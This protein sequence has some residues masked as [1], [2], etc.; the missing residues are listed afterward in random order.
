MQLRRFKGREVGDVMRQVRETLGPEAVILHT[1]AEHGARLWGLF[2]GAEVEIVAAVDDTASPQT[3]RSGEAA[4]T[5]PLPGPGRAVSGLSGELGADLAEMKMMLLRAV[6]GRVLPG[7]LATVYDTLVDSGLDAARAVR[8][9]DAITPVEGALTGMDE[10]D[11]DALE[12][13]LRQVVRVAASS[14]T[15]RPSTI[16][17]VGPA[18]AG[19]TAMVTKLAVHSHLVGHKADIV[20]FDGGSLGATAQLEAVGSMLGIPWILA[21]APDDV[22]RTLDSGPT[23]GVTLIDTPGLG[24]RNADELVALRALLD[25]ASP[26][27]V[28]LVLPAT[29]TAA[30]GLAAVRRFAVLG[31][32][33]LAFT[34]LDEAVGVGPVLAVAIESALPLSYLGTGREVPNDIKPATARDLARR[35]LQGER[36]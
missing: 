25:A 10:Q 29:M 3:S 8:V 15:P 24:T 28:H 9:V 7:R 30:D 35:V 14:L 26:A 17:F 4:A 21:A 12:A 5:R 2:G 32:T 1:K 13:R 16:A 19:K 11:G 18:G 27:E 36:P 22:A 31:C 23:R 34:R 33:H 6:G 20:S